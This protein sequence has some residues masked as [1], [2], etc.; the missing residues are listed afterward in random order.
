METVV[1][2]IKLPEAIT[3]HHL[4]RSRYTLTRQHL[5]LSL[6]HSRKDLPLMTPVLRLMAL[7]L[8]SLAGETGAQVAPTPDAVFKGLAGRAATAKVID[9]LTRHAN[10]ALIAAKAVENLSLQQ[11]LKFVQSMIDRSK[12]AEQLLISSGAINEQGSFVVTPEMIVELCHNSRSAG[13]E[14]SE[15]MAVRVIRCWISACDAIVVEATSAESITGILL[16]G[17]SVGPMAAVML[18]TRILELLYGIVRTCDR[19][20]V[21]PSNATIPE[22]ARTCIHGLRSIAATLFALPTIG[23]VTALQ[24]LCALASHPWV[25]AAIVGRISVAYDQA[26]S[27]VETRAYELGGWQLWPECHAHDVVDVDFDGMDLAPAPRTQSPDPAAMH[28]Y[29]L[30]SELMFA[31]G[32]KPD[33]INTLIE[34]IWAVMAA[35]DTYAAQTRGAMKQGAGIVMVAGASVEYVPPSRDDVRKLVT[36]PRSASGYPII[37][38][39]DARSYMLPSNRAYRFLNHNRWQYYT[40]A[41]LAR[42]AIETIPYVPMFVTDGAQKSGIKIVPQVLP[43]FHILDEGEVPRPPTVDTLAHLWH[44]TVEELRRN[45]SALSP[46]EKNPT[47]R[48]WADALRFVGLLCVAPVSQ[49]GVI[50]PGRP[51]VPSVGHY[52]HADPMLLMALP[53]GGGE[54]LEACFLSPVDVGALRGGDT[55]LVIYPFAAIPTCARVDVI[56]GHLQTLPLMVVHDHEAPVRW[57]MTGSDTDV[58]IEASAVRVLG[59][60]F[61]AS[62]VADLVLVPIPARSDDYFELQGDDSFRPSHLCPVNAVVTLLPEAEPSPVVITSDTAVTL[63][64]T[65]VPQYI[66]T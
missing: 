41:A 54:G 57:K 56:A 19:S 11:Q 30:Y 9:A 63:A 29:V 34:D 62:E 38:E 33:I 47:L 50:G 25:K 48:A 65:T 15:L 21:D 51:I 18:A 42:T 60:S 26:L 3:G 44:T 2:T 61:P 31:A 1:T 10:V 46:N 6:M 7:A 49:T 24:R 39:F 36:L 16:D 32:F 59:W 5:V 35:A 14:D 40:Q 12:L 45:I 66:N 64:E 55:H 53:A 23:H 37:S 27:A 20:V 58:T 43:L 17:S 4:Y 8:Q 52:Y 22:F 28:D 13:P